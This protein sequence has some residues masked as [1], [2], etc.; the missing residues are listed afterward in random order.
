[1][2][3]YAAALLSGRSSSKC[4]HKDETVKQLTAVV[5]QIVYTLS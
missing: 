2:Q 1:M 4:C 5:L 3:G